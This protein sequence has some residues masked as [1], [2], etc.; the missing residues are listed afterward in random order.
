METFYGQQ[1]MKAGSSGA[2]GHDAFLKLARHLDQSLVVCSIGL[3]GGRD[4]LDAL[5]DGSNMHTAEVYTLLTTFVYSDALPR[6]QRAAEMPQ[7]LPPQVCVRLGHQ[8]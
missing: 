8:H 2:R 7:H 5:S 4:R 6:V 3:D 1:R